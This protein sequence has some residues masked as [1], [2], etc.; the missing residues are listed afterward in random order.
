MSHGLLE[1]YC[2]GVAGGGIHDDQNIIMTLSRIWKGTHQIHAYSLE[3]DVNDEPRYEQSWGWFLW[4]GVL[5]LREMLTEVFHLCIHP[6]PEEM[7]LDL[8]SG[9]MAH[10]LATQWMGVGEVQSPDPLCRAGGWWW[11]RLTDLEYS[12]GT[13]QGLDQLHGLLRSPHPHSH[14]VVLE[15]L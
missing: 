11:F 5:T 3:G 9:V 13:F 8:L 7:D 10:Q 14:T 2:L 15:K 1:R 6:W 4:G 12:K